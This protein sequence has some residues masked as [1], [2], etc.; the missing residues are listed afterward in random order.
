MRV[1][2]GLPAARSQAPRAGSSQQVE[3][4]R[5][6]AGHLRSEPDELGQTFTAHTLSTAHLQ[7]EL[8][9]IAESLEHDRFMQDIA[10]NDDRAHRRM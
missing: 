9:Y 1:K 4:M 3:E 6:I 10:R 2:S 7:R 8:C 5:E